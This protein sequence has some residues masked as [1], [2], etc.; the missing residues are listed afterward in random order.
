[1]TNTKQVLPFGMWPSP[2]TPLMIGQGMQFNDTQWDSDGSTLVWVEGRSDRNVLVCQ[3]QNGAQRDLTD[4]LNV[5]AWVGY[6]GGDYTVDNGWVYFVDISGRIYRKNLHT[7]FPQPLT[8]TYGWAASPKI[9]PDGRWLL[10]VFSDRKNDL[11]AMVD[12]EGK[13]WPRKL[14]Q[15]A[16]FYMQPAWHPDGKRIA[17][18]EWDHPNMPWDQT[19][20][21]MAALGSESLAV[22]NVQTIADETDTAAVQPLFSPDGRFLSYIVG[23]GDWDDLVLLDLE[24]GQKQVLVKGKG[25]HL[26]DP[27]WGQG[28]HSYGWVGTSKAIYYTRNFGGFS[29]L[30]RVELDSGESTQIDTA[31]YTSVDQ[32][33]VSSLGNKL[34]F[35]ASAPHIPTRIVVW[36]DGKL[37]IARYSVPETVPTEFF[38]APQQ[39]S[40]KSPEGTDVFGVFYPPQ[41]PNFTCQGLP[42]VFIFAHGGPTGHIHVSYNAQRTYFTSRGYAW[43]DLN[44]RGSTG[45]GHSYR[46][47]MRQRW[48][49]V[50]TVDAAMSVQ[51]LADH[52][53]ADA[54]RAVIIGPSAG[55]YLVL[56]ALVQY[57]GVF[58]AGVDLFG[59]SNLFNLARDTHKFE[60]RY[61]DSMVGPLP[62]AAERYHQWSPV[63][64]ADKIRDP[65]AIFQGSADIVVP[66]NQ[67]EDI[68]AVLRQRGVSHIYRKYEGEGHGF[69]KTENIIDMMQQIEQFMQQY[70]V[71]S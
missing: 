46:K 20:I 68:L 24:S 38:S 48:G 51:A 6:G 8:P 62:E 18:V 57:P 58:K 32:L 59:V 35:T 43:L 33:S 53:L 67:S 66:P 63:F 61:L 65:L 47:V 13:Q 23:S 71:F 5:R 1:M 50:D 9:S 34:T 56:N 29:T 2:I 26:A 25:F 14:I 49:D 31:P 37:S 4:E 41:H 60:S 10:F 12:S 42:P 64:Q 19:R 39:I 69:H 40:W 28:M 55:G 15:G 7:G 17:W 45:Y 22:V 44:Y 70:V 52:K 21:K 54:G 27:A 3:P 11:L 36:E 16:D 30:W